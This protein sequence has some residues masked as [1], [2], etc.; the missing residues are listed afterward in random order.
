MGR[1]IVQTSEVLRGRVMAAKLREDI[2]TYYRGVVPNLPNELRGIIGEFL[3]DK[4]EVKLQAVALLAQDED[5][6]TEL[7]AVYYRVFVNLAN[8]TQSGAQFEYVKVVAKEIGLLKP[9]KPLAFKDQTTQAETLLTDR[10]WHYMQGVKEIYGRSMVAATIL[11]GVQ[12][13]LDDERTHGV[14]VKIFGMLDKAVHPWLPYGLM[15]TLALHYPAG[16][17]REAYFAALLH[18]VGNEHSSK[19]FRHKGPIVMARHLKRFITQG[20]DAGSLLKQVEAFLMERP[21]KKVA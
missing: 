13:N 7:G 20:A 19:E 12:V 14:F 10:F 2:L 11:K 1:E 9:V 16:E 18:F 8:S 4:D 3:K 6:L 21:T 17:K 15:E 5:F